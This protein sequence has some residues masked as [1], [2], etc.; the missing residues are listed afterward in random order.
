MAMIGE[1]DPRVQALYDDNLAKTRRATAEVSAELKAGQDKVAA[2]IA[3]REDKHKR[4][5]TEARESAENLVKQGEKQQPRKPQWERP[6]RGTGEMAFGPEDD[7]GYAPAPQA[8]TPP[9]PPVAPAPVAPPPPPARP[10]RAAPVDDDDDLSGQ[11]W[12]S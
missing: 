4:D 10:R 2:D 9:P 6:E 7:D 3:A 8:A 12:L 5:L 11:T 1:V